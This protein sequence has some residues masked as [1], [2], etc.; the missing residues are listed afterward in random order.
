MVRRRRLA[1]LGDRIIFARKFQPAATFFQSR[2]EV[3]GGRVL[4]EGHFRFEGMLALGLNG[5]ACRPS[6]NVPRRPPAPGEQSSR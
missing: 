5:T 1:P 3:E 6:M 4:H 2:Q